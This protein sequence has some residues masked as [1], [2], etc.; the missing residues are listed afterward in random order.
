LLGVVVAVDQ[1]MAGAV[2]AVSVQAQDFLLPLVL[3]TQLP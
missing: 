1:L 3:L 2:R